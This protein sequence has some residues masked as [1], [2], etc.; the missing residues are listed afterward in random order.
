MAWRLLAELSRENAMPERKEKKREEKKEEMRATLLIETH[1]PFAE[2]KRS[3]QVSINPRHRE[4]GKKRVGVDWRKNSGDSI[5]TTMKIKRRQNTTAQHRNSWS[6]Y[7]IIIESFF[8]WVEASK[9]TS[10]EQLT[11][12]LCPIQTVLSTLAWYCLPRNI[13]LQI[14]KINRRMNSFCL[15]IPINNLTP[16]PIKLRNCD[17]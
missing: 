12:Q 9:C 8:K 15:P 11:P 13:Q 3:K 7:C 6:H 1:K 2:S 4:H 16:A 14:K 17:D 10:I 5:K